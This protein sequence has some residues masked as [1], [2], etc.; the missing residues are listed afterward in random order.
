MYNMVMLYILICPFS[1]TLLKM[2]F[3][4]IDLAW[5]SSDW[6]KFLV[7]SILSIRVVPQTNETLTF[8]FFDTCQQ[9][10]SMNWHMS[11]HEWSRNTTQE[12]DQTNLTFWTL[13]IDNEKNL[14]LFKKKT[15]QKVARARK[16]LDLFVLASYYWVSFLRSSENVSEAR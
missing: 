5:I 15:K 16:N 9:L 3:L 11:S 2:E 1:I 12:Y 4:T 10:I 8:V 14:R 13:I 6:Y 7:S